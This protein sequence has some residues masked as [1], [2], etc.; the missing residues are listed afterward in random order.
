MYLDQTADEIESEK[1]YSI[2]KYTCQPFMQL[3][4]HYTPSS[5][6]REGGG[7]VIPHL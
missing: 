4:S 5:F 7:E 6:G 1:G 3:A 2:V